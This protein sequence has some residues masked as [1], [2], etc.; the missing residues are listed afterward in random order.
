[1][2]LINWQDVYSAGYTQCAFSL[3]HKK[4]I[5]LHDKYFPEQSFTK[6]YHT[7]KPWLTTCL[8]EAIKKKNKLYYESIKIKCLRTK[9][10][11]VFYR[12]QLRKQYWW[13][14]QKRNTTLTESW[15]TNNSRKLWSLNKNIIN[16]NEKSKFQEKIQIK[17]W[18]IY[19]W[20]EN[21]LW[22]F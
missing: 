9:E 6:R 3:F 20:Y 14:L 7:R 4:M 15:K 13:E 18:F 19:N 21:I 12:N 16:R 8:R 17:W 1:M 11:Y 5:D 10:G 22:K 2:A